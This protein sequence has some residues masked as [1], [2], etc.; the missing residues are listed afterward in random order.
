[1]TLQEQYIERL[2]GMVV[3]KYGRDIA[4]VDECCALAEAVAEATDMR[5]SAKDYASLFM[6]QSGVAPR[7]VTLS[8]LAQYVGYD[9][10]SSFCSSSDVTPA[11]DSDILP[12]PR[13]W[14]VVIL[15]ALAVVV[16]IITAMLLLGN[17]DKKTETESVTI[18]TVITSVEDRWHARTVEECN[19]VRAYFDDEDYAERV[20]SFI[21]D[22]CT[23]LYDDISA[24]L[25]Y[26][27]EQVGIELS[28][29][30]I[31][32]YTECI[33]TSCSAMCQSLSAEIKTTLVED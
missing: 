20:D 16:V 25:I 30:D 10:W 26:D 15:T 11:A 3:V 31:A 7:P 6:P 12:T 17:G 9:S 19:A 24:A 8:A 27:A 14:G 1:M 21:E 23:T 33:A 29:E 28:D 32:L 18:E 22:Y 2:R 5:L 13:Y 4:S